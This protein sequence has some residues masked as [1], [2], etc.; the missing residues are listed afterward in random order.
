MNRSKLKRNSI[1]GL[2]E[3]D[4]AIVAEQVAALDKVLSVYD[5]ILATQ[6]YL[7]GSEI[8]LADLNHL[9][10]A[11]MVR[12]AGYRELWEKYPNVS[13]WWDVMEGRESFK[14]VFG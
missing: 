3:P 4:A 2:G 6:S 11:K 9:P 14:R 8:T 1:Q 12:D 7:A 10:Y 13:R 5:G